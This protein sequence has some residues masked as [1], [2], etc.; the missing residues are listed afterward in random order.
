MTVKVKKE[1]AKIDKTFITTF[2]FDNQWQRMGLHDDDLRK[3]Q[4]E[5]M[6]NPK[7]G[8]VIRRHRRIEEKTFR[9]KRKREKRQLSYFVC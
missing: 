1:G 7:L 4:N 9:D 5:I 8:R 2:E 3:L 6:D